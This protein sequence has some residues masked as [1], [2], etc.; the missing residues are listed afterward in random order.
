MMLALARLGR[1]THSTSKQLVRITLVVD[2]KS[3][4]MVL[5]K[6]RRLAQCLEDVGVP[7]DFDCGYCCDCGTCG[8]KFVEPVYGLLAKEQ[9]IS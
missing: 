3:S 8:V 6:G 5:E 2:G 4:P 7:L 1:W 9:P